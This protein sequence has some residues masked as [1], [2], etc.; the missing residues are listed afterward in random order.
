MF[1]GCGREGRAGFEGAPEGGASF[2]PSPI[3]RLEFLFSSIIII[4]LDCI[5][6]KKDWNFGRLGA[7][8]RFIFSKRP[9]SFYL[10]L[11][12]SAISISNGIVAERTY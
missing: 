12:G 8:G 11:L 1:S 7:W 6:D 3:Y 2:L 4:F 9:V 10:S 5:W